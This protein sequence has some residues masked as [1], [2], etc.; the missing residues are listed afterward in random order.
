ML[1]LICALFALSYLVNGESI[2][3]QLGLMPHVMPHVST[4]GFGGSHLEEAYVVYTQLP[5]GEVALR[6]AGWTKHDQQGCNPNLGYAWTM[7]SSGATESH[8]LKLY[9]TEAGQM[10]G[11]GVVIEGAMYKPSLP[12]PQSKYATQ[13]PLVSFKRMPWNNA[14]SHIDVAFRAG[15]IL[16]SGK[17]SNATL[18]DRLIVNPGAHPPA[19]SKEIPL[20]ESKVR[21]EGYSRGSCFDGMGWHWFLDT[22]R[23]DGTLSW[24]SANLFPVVPMYHGGEINAIFFASTVNQ[25]GLISARMWEPVPLANW[26]MCE[27][28]CDDECTF[29][30]TN[31]WSTM[32][33][34]FRSHKDVSCDAQQNHL[35]CAIGN[36]VGCCEKKKAT[37]SYSYGYSGSLIAGTRQETTS[38]GHS[39]SWIAPSVGVAAFVIGAIATRTL[40]SRRCPGRP[41]GYAE[42][43]E[44]QS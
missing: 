36:G 8:P 35:T 34:Y 40:L 14:E 39:A 37:Y 5:L 22:S 28:L 26:A 1:R 30:G 32:H 44:T 19:Q 9:T 20:K 23:A 17:L 4:Q 21:T 6:A 41:D 38:D 13:R 11:V 7:D 15:P 2:G 29:A 27:N 33:I 24:N 16:C 42:L 43:Q 31:L 12:P 10:A 25:H 3:E 18:G